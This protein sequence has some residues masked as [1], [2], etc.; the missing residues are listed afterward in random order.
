LHGFPE[1][2]AAYEDI[3]PVLADAGYFA[4]AYDQRGYSPGA[5]P[6]DLED[7][8]ILNAVSDVS[9]VVDTLGAKSFHLVGHDW[10]GAVGW[11][12][13]ALH[14][15]R[16]KSLTSLAT[17]H[18]DAVN[19]GI[20]DPGHPQ[21][22]K[23]AYMEVFRA[24]NSE[25]LF[26]GDGNDPKENF[27]KVVAAGGV[28]AGKAAAYAEVLGSKEACWSAL[29]WYRANPL[30]TEVK[31]GPI[32]VPTLFIYG[33]QDLAFAPETAVATASLVAAPYTYLQLPDEGH[34]IPEAAPYLVAG[35]FIEHA[36]RFGRPEETP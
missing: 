17:P 19:A 36:A 22:L 8:Q 10:G 25:D 28:P 34:W 12:Y 15:N 14:P 2:S 3:L 32:S 31:I 30:P 21:H 9:H 16:L 11:V 4:V 24:H 33:A 1:S 20:A 5:R 6:Q 7:Y 29:N 23:S 26:L 27:K 13:A 35:A 18:L